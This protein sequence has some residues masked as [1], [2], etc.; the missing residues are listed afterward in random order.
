MVL[1]TATLALV[2]VFEELNNHMAISSILMKIDTEITSCQ[3]RVVMQA[4]TTN[5]SKSVAL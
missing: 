2:G 4:F 1:Y 3:T 5:T